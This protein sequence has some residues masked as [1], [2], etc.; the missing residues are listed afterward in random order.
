MKRIAPGYWMT[1]VLGVLVVVLSFGICGENQTGISIKIQDI[2]INTLLINGLIPTTANN[3]VVRG[4][5]FVG[6]LIIFYLLTPL[7]SYVYQKVSQ[8]GKFILPIAFFMLSTLVL[9]ALSIVDERMTCRNNSFFY[10]SFVNQ[11]SCFLLGFTLRDLYEKK[12]LD[13]VSKPLLKGLI[14]CVLSVVL[15]FGG[16]YYLTNVAFTIIPFVVGL[17]TVFLSCHFLKKSNSNSQSL[18][19]SIAIKFGELDFVIMLIH[20]FIVF[21]LCKII[22]HYVN[23]PHIALF[24]VLIPIEIVLIYYM[25]KGYKALI[26]KFTALLFKNA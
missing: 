19:K 8:K 9:T 17:A 23:L 10:F 16:Y 3:H 5:W 2:I 7:F 26:N 12:Q 1:I 20:P 13:E 4:G 22:I 6:T 11:V 14:I 15:F 18:W 24:F 21:D 25:S